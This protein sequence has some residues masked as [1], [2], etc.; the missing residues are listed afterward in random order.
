MGTQRSGRWWMVCVFAAGLICGARPGRAADD[1]ILTVARA[2]DGYRI[3]GSFTTA[4]PR[5]V[6]WAVLTDYDDLDQFVSSMRTSRVLRR[7]RDSLIVEQVAVGR[8]FLFSRTIHL[9]LEVREEPFDTIRFADISHRDLRAYRGEWEMHDVPGG[10]RVDY[11]VRAADPG[12]SSFF[13]ERG[14]RG[15]SRGLLHEIKQEIEKRALRAGTTHPAAESTAP[16]GDGTPMT[17]AHPARSV[18]KR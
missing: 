13:A 1:V 14:I 17:P 15:V 10:T 9:V 3:H 16:S 12:G 18:G 8:V 11:N 2:K 7:T 4:A 5:A 6:T